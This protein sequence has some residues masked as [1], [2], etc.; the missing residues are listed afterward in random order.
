MD[1]LSKRLLKQHPRVKMGA[2][3]TKESQ[4]WG[5][6]AGELG[7][8]DDGMEDDQDSD[9]NFD[10]DDDEGESRSY[11]RRCPQLPSPLAA[12]S[13]RLLRVMWLHVTDMAMAMAT[14][15][16]TT[17]AAAAAGYGGIGAAMMGVMHAAM[18]MEGGTQ[19]PCTCSLPTA[20]QCRQ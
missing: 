2:V 17:S 19:A 20:G 7:F 11:G 9:D 16:T 15:I 5:G 6:L 18:Q 13:A 14:T 12:L 4:E 10:S 3:W 8:G 1:R